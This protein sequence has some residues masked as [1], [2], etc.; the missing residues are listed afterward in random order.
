[1]IYLQ[2]DFSISY[3]DQDILKISKIIEKVKLLFSINIFI[4]NYFNINLFTCSLRKEIQIIIL[5]KEDG[6]LKKP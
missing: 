6:L 4:L 5:D 3:K 1:M 2:I